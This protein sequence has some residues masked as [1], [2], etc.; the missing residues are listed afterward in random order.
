MRLPTLD[1]DDTTECREAIRKIEL[2]GVSKVGHSD[3]PVVRSAA[4]TDVV[5]DGTSSIDLCTYQ[6]LRSFVSLRQPYEMYY[7]F[8]EAD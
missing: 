3:Q 2:N 7:E 1:I 6:M 8:S 5:V 4:T